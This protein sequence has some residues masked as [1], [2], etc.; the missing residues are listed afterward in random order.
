MCACTNGQVGPVCIIASQAQMSLLA[1]M[2]Q[3]KQRLAGMQRRGE[4]EIDHAAPV[5]D[6]V[7][8]RTLRTG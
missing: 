5:K 6:D 1:H 7:G 8:D 4:G 3:G 2:L